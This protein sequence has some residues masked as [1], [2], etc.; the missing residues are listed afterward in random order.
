MAEFVDFSSK[1]DVKPSI[2]RQQLED[3]DDHEQLIEV[4]TK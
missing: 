4:R 1:A 3:A 2:L